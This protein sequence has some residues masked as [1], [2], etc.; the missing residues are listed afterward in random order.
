MNAMPSPHA[1]PPPR[2][3]SPGA[4]L[5]T[6]VALLLAVALAGCDLTATAESDSVCVS[7]PLTTSPL[8]ATPA[9]APSVPALSLPVTVGFDLGAAVPS[10]L[11]ENGVT[12]EL[13]GRSISI[14]TPEGADLS[15]IE[16]AAITV[17]RPGNDAD[18]VVFS[19]TRPAGATGVTEVRATP[20]RSVNLVD[21]LQDQRFLS[22][23]DVTVGG[24]APAVPWTP[25]VKTCARAKV[26]VDEAEAAGL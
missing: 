16:T 14:V 20:D 24:R 10:D 12:A 26:E 7:E 21:Y 5:Q 22:V 13:I 18:V 15:G 17:V 19:Y 3:L 1:A 6:P 2:V 4:R 25:T 9:G 11:G 23:R 8:P